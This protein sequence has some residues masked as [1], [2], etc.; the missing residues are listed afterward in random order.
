[1][2]R[3]APALEEAV[4]P[5]PG[6]GAIYAPAN[7]RRTR[8]SRRDAV[9]VAGARALHETPGIGDAGATVNSNGHAASDQ[10]QQ[11]GRV[12]RRGRPRAPRAEKI[13][14]PNAASTGIDSLAVGSPPAS[15]ASAAAAEALVINLSG[16]KPNRG[17]RTAKRARRKQ[18]DAAAALNGADDNPALGALN[19]HLNMMMQQLGTAHRV[20][21]RIAAERDALRQ[22][23]A[24]LQGIP[25]EEIVV[26]SLGASNDQFSAAPRPSEP[27]PKTGISRLNYFG[28]EDV[29]KTSP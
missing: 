1:V 14:S 12:E 4:A 16:K 5:S 24:D 22:Q 26:T 27:P 2:S 19:R 15:D 23:L 6:A 13:V 28:G 8:R 25:V 9:G 7:E 21:G 18:E 10:S 11:A 3:E 20:I 17:V 29:A